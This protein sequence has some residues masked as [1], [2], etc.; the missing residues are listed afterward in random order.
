MAPHNVEVEA[1]TDTTGVP[2]PDPLTAAMPINDIRGRRK[3]A[4]KTTWGV[5]APASSE[6][7]KSYSHTHKP[8]A[9]RWD[10]YISTESKS[11]K[12]NSLKNAAKYL[13]KPGLISLGGGLPSS[14]YFPFDSLD[15]TMPAVGKFSEQETKTDGVTVHVGKHDLAEDKSIFD[16]ATAFNYG[17]GHGAAQL[18]RW[19]TEHTELVHNP[20]YADWACHMTVGS[21]SALDMSL[22]I[23]TE[24]GD[25]IL[26]E[27][28]T[29]ATAIETAAPLGVKVAGIKMDEQG[30]LPE[31]LDEVLTN[32]DPAA[33][34]GARKPFVLYTV[35]SG[36]NPTGAT[37]GANRRREIYKVAQKHDLYIFEDEPYYFL[38]MEPYGGADAATPE[39]PSSHAEFMESLVPSLLSM[40]V[41]GRVLRMDSFSKVVSPGSRVGWITGAVQVVERYAKHA[42][43]STQGPSGMSQLILFK[44]LDEHWG[45]PGYIDWLIHI[46]KEYTH[47]RDVMLRACDKYLPK[48]V[49]SWKPPMAG[50]FH[51]LQIDW[52]KHPHASTKSLTELE[53]EIFMLIIDH[54][55]L[56][57]KGSWF[58]AEPDAA[59]DTMFFRATFAAA[60]ADK[61]QEAI[62]RFGDAIRHSFKLKN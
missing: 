6:R 28:Y 60:P 44:L 34:G 32:W 41:D 56:V 59:H 46:R 42:D 43:V 47:R 39:P 3:K 54:G 36:Q 21:T 24:P 37:Q 49:V 30:L 10:H 9:K 25:Y 62:H 58:Y 33:R 61:I 52:R 13:G 1:I 18:L 17:Q 15:L 14:E 45:H 29:F 12:G 55:A 35:P 57:M 48:D 16:I 5:A 2:L 40:D 11:R 4:E 23:F 50:M 22:R 20:P 53:D 26:S 7:F 31:S 51:W 19:V 38:Q 27:D 8:K